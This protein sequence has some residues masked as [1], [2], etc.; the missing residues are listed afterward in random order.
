MR[1]IVNALVTSRLDYCNSLLYGSPSSL[2][3]RLQSVQ[4]CAARL[5]HNVSKFAPSFRLLSTLHWLPMKHRIAF[6]ILLITYKAVHTLAPLNITQLIKVKK[7]SGNLRSSNAILPRTHPFNPQ[8][9]LVIARF[10]L[11]LLLS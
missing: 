3:S 5:T 7:S 6:K 8:Q 9:L 10:P 4:N 2:L 1:T 11:L